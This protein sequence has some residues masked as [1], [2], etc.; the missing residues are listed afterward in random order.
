MDAFTLAILTIFGGTI[1]GLIAIF[2]SSYSSFQ[3]EKALIL[4]FCQEFMLLYKRCAMYYEQ[5][6]KNSVSFSTLYEASNTGTIEKLAEKIS[7]YDILRSIIKLKADFFQIIRWAHRASRQDAIDSGAQ[8]RA[9]VFFMGDV[10][11]LDG[12]YGRTRY[13]LYRKDID[14]VLNYL[15]WLDRK[16]N[17][18]SL[19]DYLK[20]LLIGRR[21]SLKDFIAK[22]RTE[23][24]ESENTL[25]RLRLQEQK[26]WIKEGK[27]F[28]EKES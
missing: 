10:T 9:V 1:G 3:Q 17:L 12:S 20:Q 28:I 5:M 7:D 2:Y 26:A 18:L 8:S 21:K 22:S 4:L 11:A 15:E 16:K 25:D 6:L 24:N 23:L 13:R 19:I 14:E 27:A